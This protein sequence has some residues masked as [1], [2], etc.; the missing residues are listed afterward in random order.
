MSC[1]YDLESTGSF[2]ILAQSEEEA[3]EWGDQLAEWYVKNLF[4]SKASAGWKACGYASWIE[5][6]PDDVLRKA[7]ESSE[8]ILKGSL[9]DLELVW[10]AFSD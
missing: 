6:E 8:G 2:R 5:H 9:P 4:G 3:L 10:I 7:A 1:D